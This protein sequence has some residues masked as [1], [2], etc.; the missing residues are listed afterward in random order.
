[1]KKIFT[2]LTVLVSVASILWTG[3]RRS[4]AEE[5]EGQTVKIG[6]ASDIEAEVWQVVADKAKKEGITLDITLFTDYVQPNEA[7]AN[8]SLDLNAFQHIAY[9]NEWNEANEGSLVPLGFTYVTSLGLYSEKVEDIKDIP[10]G[11]TIA[12]PNDPTNGGRALLALQQAKFIKV[13]EAAGIL[14]TTEDITDNPLELSFE[15]IDAAQLASVL[16]DV[17]AAFINNNFALDAGLS[18]DDA[19][20]RDGEDLSAL[21]DDYK[22]VVAVDKKRQKDPL[23]KHIVDLYQSKKVE[24]KLAELSDGGD[25]PAWEKK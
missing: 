6:V 4:L 22:N 24:E 16:P 17:D 5:F 2:L 1:M 21:K 19:I 20:F 25:I 14:P 10:K 12:I 7:L 18:I 11:A 8:G 3:S 13:D 9:L 23:L 15:E